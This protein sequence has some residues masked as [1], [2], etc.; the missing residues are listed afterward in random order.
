MTATN[1]DAS[2]AFVWRPGFDSPLDGYHVSEN[3]PGGGTNGGVIE[4]TWE[5][6]SRKGLVRGTL[7]KATKAQL[8]TVLRTLFWGTACDRLPSGLDLALFNGR[9]M[10]AGFPAIF[11]QCL[12]FTDVDVDG[13]IGR[14][15]VDA[16]R[17]L[18]APTLIDALFGN[19][20]AY[21]TRLDG[22]STFG[23]G[24]ATRLKA[25]HGA[26]MQIATQQSAG[27]PLGLS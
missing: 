13:V 22:W 27:R 10:S 16:A 3:D 2:L 11:Q 17:V 19:H 1:Y 23:D 4:A 20:Y 15:T 25:A 6:A 9:M 8:S 14:Q 5:V 7:A 12:G 18:H 26:A 24:W 21:L